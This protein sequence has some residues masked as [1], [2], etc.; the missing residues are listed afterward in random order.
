MLKRTAY[1]SLHFSGALFAIILLSSCADFEQERKQE[2]IRVAQKNRDEQ[3]LKLQE[4]KRKEQE[5]AEKKRREEQELAEQ[6]RQQELLL[7]Q[8]PSWEMFDRTCKTFYDSAGHDREAWNVIAMMLYAKIYQKVGASPAD[9]KTHYQHCLQNIINGIASAYPKKRG[10]DGDLVF[11]KNIYRPI[12]R[13][14]HHLS[15]NDIYHIAVNLNLASSKECSDYSTANA[16]ALL[17]A[18]SIPKNQALFNA[19]DKFWFIRLRAACTLGDIAKADE[20]LNEYSEKCKLEDYIV[21]ICDACSKDK[22]DMVKFLLPAVNSNEFRSNLA[23]AFQMMQDLS[24]LKEHEATIVTHRIGLNKMTEM[25]KTVGMGDM[26]AAAIVNSNGR[27]LPLLLEKF[28][29][30]TKSLVFLIEIAV[31]HPNTAENVLCLIKKFEASRDHADKNH[32]IDCSNLL[33]QGNTAVLKELM[34]AGIQISLASLPAIIA[35]NG[36]KVLASID[37][38]MVGK[39]PLMLASKEM[40]QA[41]LAAAAVGNVKVLK[42]LVQY[43]GEVNCMDENEKSPLAIAK[44]KNH[45]ECVAYLESVNAVSSKFQLRNICKRIKEKREHLAVQLKNIEPKREESPS[46]QG[47]NEFMTKIKKYQDDLSRRQAEM[48]KNLSGK[49]RVLVETLLKAK[50]SYGDPRHCFFNLA[51]ARAQVFK[52]GDSNRFEILIYPEHSPAIQM[53][54]NEIKQRSIA[55][56]RKFLSLED[57][58]LLDLL[59]QTEFKHPE[60]AHITVLEDGDLIRIVAVSPAN[61]F[62]KFD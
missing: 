33:I 46:G 16:Q 48:L 17:R 2:E 21:L 56:I 14:G 58:L 61:V 22:P 26:F 36:P 24:R 11:K 1:H 15:N 6:K 35:D 27:C 52:T 40:D 31:K 3:A 13:Y 59:I 39:T 9:N 4:Q 41:M 19:I 25:I 60:K 10:K 7:T 37:A 54:R 30:D 62:V 20:I 43:G 50:I 42:K 34:R 57:S 55:E 38:V 51:F 5:L 47:G 18:Y 45:Q 49:N 44:E 53:L 8:G 23:E 29:L 32:F 28:P 12:M